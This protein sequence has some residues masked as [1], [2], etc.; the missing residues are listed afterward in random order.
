[1]EN[2]VYE[3]NA[4]DFFWKTIEAL[5]GSAVKMDSLEAYRQFDAIY[6]PIAFS[7]ACRIVWIGNLKETHFYHVGVR[8]YDEEVE[9]ETFNPKRISDY[10]HTIN[11]IH[12]EFQNPQQISDNLLNN[13]DVNI[14]SLST[15]EIFNESGT[16]A[17]DGI[18]AQT[19]PARA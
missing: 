16:A 8:V 17:I 15:T 18:I 12:D 3:G 1:M 10:I 19:S 13:V 14:Q 7:K 9:A 2:P 11:D 5:T 6:F 4:E